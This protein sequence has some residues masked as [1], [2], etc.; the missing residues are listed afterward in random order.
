MKKL[1]GKNRTSAWKENG[2]KLSLL[3]VPRTKENM[4]WSPILS[5][6]QRYFHSSLIHEEKSDH[7]IAV[8]S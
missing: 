7:D 3:L 8:M 4:N 1:P 2:R 6:L 5:I